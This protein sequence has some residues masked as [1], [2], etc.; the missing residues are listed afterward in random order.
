MYSD[1]GISAE[2][3]TGV[4][5]FQA[6]GLTVKSDNARYVPLFLAKADLDAAINGA[7]SQRKAARAA[8]AKAKAS[9]AAKEL[10]SARTAVRRTFW[11]HVQ[12]A[13]GSKESRTS[14]RQI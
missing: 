10:S 11:G 14:V 1:A 5:V 9:E 12:P 8:S 2:G 13:P 6:E 7:F 4:P 3:F